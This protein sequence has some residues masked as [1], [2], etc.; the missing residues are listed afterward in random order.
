MDIPLRCFNLVPRCLP[1]VVSVWDLIYEGLDMRRF[2]EAD[3]EIVV[4][5]TALRVVTRGGDVRL[6]CT[7]GTQVFIDPGVTARSDMARHFR[8]LRNGQPL[9]KIAFGHVSEIYPVPGLPITHISH[10]YKQTEET[11]QNQSYLVACIMIEIPTV[12]QWYQITCVRG[13]AII[14]HQGQPQ[15]CLEHGDRYLL[16]RYSVRCTMDDGFGKISVMLSDASLI[17]KIGVR[18]FNLISIREFDAAN[19][20]PAPIS[21]L[22]NTNW[23]LTIS[24]GHRI[25][26]SLLE[27]R[28]AGVSPVPLTVIPPDEPGKRLLTHLIYF[29]T[30][31]QQNLSEM[32]YA[33]THDIGTLEDRWEPGVDVSEQSQN[34]PSS[35]GSFSPS[36]D[37]AGGGNVAG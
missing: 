8:V 18:S 6:Q 7:V 23:L 32:L 22:I 12:Q 37:Q 19:T 10:L 34:M 33:P 11:L 15:A 35:Q 14:N 24:Q 9:R 26:D 1:I 20:L 5:A 36:V 13:D 29:C 31:V 4:V 16:Y 3:T 25:D 2:T 28:G 27:F 17:A 21:N 30:H